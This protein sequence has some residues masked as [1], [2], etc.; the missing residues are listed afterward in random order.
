MFNVAQTLEFYMKEERKRDRDTTLNDGGNV[1]RQRIDDKDDKS[2]RIKELLAQYIG[3]DDQQQDNDRVELS[4]DALSSTLIV[5]EEQSWRLYDLL[6]DERVL[7]VDCEASGGMN[8]F[9]RLSLVQIGTESGQTFLV[10]VFTGGAGAMQGVNALLEDCS[11]VK[12]LHD[13]RADS[14]LLW[15]AHGA[16]LDNVFDSQIG[17]AVFCLSQSGDV[18]LPI[19]LDKLHRRFGY[20]QLSQTKTEARADMAD[21][22]AYWERRPMSDVQLEY[23]RNDVRYL[24]DVCKQLRGPLSARS[25]HKIE[26][27]S[28]LYAAMYR[29]TSDEGRRNELTAQQRQ[30]DLG[31]IFVPS[32]HFDDWDDRCQQGA[33]IS[34]PSMRERRIKRQ[35]FQPS[36]S[37]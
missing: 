12:V 10:D 37:T 20:T 31:A 16:R 7:A 5:S 2:E 35:R 36:F 32:Y 3:I 8:R 1:K 11:I 19:G 23:A 24:V 28:A 26:Q 21:D 6:R 14:E 25:R 18:P 9:G 15:H 17:Y 13:C 29:D 33:R 34:T 4:L 22:D 30:R 27:R